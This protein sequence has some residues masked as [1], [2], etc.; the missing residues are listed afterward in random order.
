MSQQRTQVLRSAGVSPAFSH[1]YSLKN[2]LQDADATT[3]RAP[4]SLHV[5]A[6]KF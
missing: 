4:N 6:A 5:A 2:S 1:F 3:L